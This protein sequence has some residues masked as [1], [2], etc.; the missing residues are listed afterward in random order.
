MPGHG[1][2]VRRRE[3][4]EFQE[5]LRTLGVMGFYCFAY[6]DYFDDVYICPN[7]LQCII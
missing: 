5:R 4:N 3:S 1:S 6:G 7:L 2:G